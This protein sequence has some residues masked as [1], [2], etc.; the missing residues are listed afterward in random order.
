MRC[1]SWHC[2]CKKV[3]SQKCHRRVYK[4]IKWGIVRVNSEDK[5]KHS[6][7]EVWK[8]YFFALFPHSVFIA[9]DSFSIPTV[10]VSTTNHLSL[11]YKFYYIKNI[12]KHFQTCSQISDACKIIQ[13]AV[14]FVLLFDDFNSSLH[15]SLLACITS[16]TVS[17]PVYSSKAVNESNKELAGTCRVHM[18]PLM[19]IWVL[20]YH[21]E[22]IINNRS[23]H[24]R[25]ITGIN[26]RAI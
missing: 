26:V 10:V 8:V 16:L 24:I 6:K 22:I 25:Y 11:C 9:L 5:Q 12:T 7:S 3:P 15:S 18:V 14:S 17:S 4:Y 21:N 13:T 2:R 20:N 1:H 19:I 23:D